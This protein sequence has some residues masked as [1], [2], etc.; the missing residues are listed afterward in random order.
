MI[1][2]LNMIH[3]DGSQGEGGGQILRTSV[4]LSLVTGQP[5][6]I[7]DIRGGRKKPGLL[8]QHLTAVKAAAEISDAKVTGA[9][10]SS[11]ELEFRPGTVKPGTYRYAVGTAGSAT[12]V[13]QTVLP[14]LLTASGKS[15]LELE[16]GTHNMWAPPYDFLTRSFIPLINRMGPKIETELLRY[17]FYPA[18]GGRFT[19]DITPAS[20]LKPF[21]LTERGE[22]K[23]RDIRAVLAQLPGDIGKREIIMAAKKLEWDDMP[24][25]IDQIRDSQGPGN[26]VLIILEYENVTEV[27]TSFGQK[28]VKAEHVAVLAAKEASKYL[29]ADAPVGMHLADQLLVPLAIAGSGRFRTVSP[30]RHT[31]TNAEVIKEF[32]NR[33]ITIDKHEGK[34]FEVTIR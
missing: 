7:T 11:T 32:L 8:R 6:R 4:S 10:L 12:L 5:F 34:V 26:V 17:G 20:A 19:V 25:H 3:I 23:S 24:L 22:Q 28:G 31:Q 2:E 14:A 13:L 21:E 33:D 15:S 16:G 9:E 29:K 27:I 30:T 18:G 1:L